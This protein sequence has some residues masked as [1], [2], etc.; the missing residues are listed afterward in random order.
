MPVR[1]G[2][3]FAAL[4]R[5]VFR[6]TGARLII[7]AALRAQN[8]ALRRSWDAFPA[9]NNHLILAALRAL[10]FAFRRCLG[11]LPG[12]GQRGPVRGYAR[13]SDTKL[14]F[15]G[16]GRHRRHRRRADRHGNQSLTARQSR[17]LLLIS[18]RVDCVNTPAPL[19]SPPQQLSA[20]LPF[21]GRH[22]KR[23]VASP[24]LNSPEQREGDGRCWAN[25]Q[26]T[27]FSA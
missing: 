9:W 16:L 14:R 17:D 18:G 8:L 19:A 13:Q 24:S 25:L 11:R 1:R 20:V 2:I 26:N 6:R 22:Q 10:N 7:F 23:G 27:H 3:G 15:A 12:V 4:R 21:N 5:D